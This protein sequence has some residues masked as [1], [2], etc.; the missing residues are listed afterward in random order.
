MQIGLLFTSRCNAACTH[1]STSCGPDKT[2]A[3]SKQDILSLMD[4]TAE[5]KDGRPLI[6]SL[7][8]GEPFL[9]LQQLLEVIAHGARLGG[10]VTCVT[11]GY[12][13]ASDEKARSTLEAVKAAGLTALGVS[14]SQFHQQYIKLDRV[15]RALTMAVEIGLGTVLKLAYVKSDRR[16][17]EELEA[18]ANSIGVKRVERFPVLPYVREGHQLP[19][20]EFETE[21]G[22]PV[23]TC[24]SPSFTI[25]EDGTAYSCCTP[26]GF[27]KALSFG[28]VTGTNLRDAY[29][30]FLLQGLQTLLREEG[31]I[32]L[33][34]A[35]R[36]QGLGHL[37]RDSYVGV[38]D[39]CA[40][41]ASEPR[42][43]ALARRV[44]RAY[45]R[46]RIH[47]LFRGV[48]RQ[49][50]SPAKKALVSIQT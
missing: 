43:A 3:L 27:V 33:A 47:P 6:F 20:E 42:L 1:C 44:A 17:A 11:N 7:S 35:A 50:S 13:A 34:Q 32:H 12:W 23:G 9:D 45:E 2:R 24:P 49:R 5:I 10:Q 38:C 19:M 36:K 46:E 16:H 39:L 31:P 18:W 15:K 14:A 8:G 30:R 26:G 22:L 28:K 4:E 48:I 37:L 41:L 21:P 29:H 40:H 25:R